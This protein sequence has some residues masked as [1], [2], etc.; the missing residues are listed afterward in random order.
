MN[1]TLVKA[2][3]KV[4]KLVKGPRKATGDLGKQSAFLKVT[5]VNVVE[6]EGEFQR[7]SPFLL[8]DEG[9]MPPLSDVRLKYVQHSYATL[10]S[11]VNRHW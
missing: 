2:S 10:R 8:F 9:G 11:K 1:L 6:H 3:T 4:F 5:R 7:C